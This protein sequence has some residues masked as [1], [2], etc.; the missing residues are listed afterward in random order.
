VLIR[1]LAL[2]ETLI[3]VLAHLLPFNYPWIGTQGY[4][5]KFFKSRT[6]RHWITMVRYLFVKYLL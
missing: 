3:W 4:S 2:A 6:K 1:N 5:S